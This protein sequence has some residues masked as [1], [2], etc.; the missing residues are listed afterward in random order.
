MVDWLMRRV[1]PALRRFA[2]AA[3]ALIVA[4]LAMSSPLPPLALPT[5]TRLAA[6]QSALPGSGIEATTLA[7]RHLDEA[8]SDRRWVLRRG[9]PLNEDAHAHAG[10]FVYAAIGASYL[11]VEDTQG[12]L[13]QEGQAAWAPGGIG[14][15]H[16]TP[17]RASNRERASSTA[18]TEIWTILLER[19]TD[20]RRPGAAATSP[21]LLQLPPGPYEARLVALTFQP[22][23][24]TAFRSRTGPELAYTL[25]GSWELE[26]A[27]VPF[28][29][30]VS[31]GY[32]AD[33]G[34]PH[35]LRNV[36]ET[37][38]RLLSAQLVPAGQP[39]EEPS[40]AQAPNPRSQR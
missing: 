37:P 32:L 18:E 11:V 15:L 2:S 22:S 27:G 16:A 7:T 31:Q 20:S 39:A 21:P 8:P 28:S 14:H 17:F 1:Q 25:S 38:A 12:S 6:A 10:G 3:G 5:S 34:V 29:L 35:R 9:H 36:G 13:M 23:V 4:A 19:E 40:S 30:G 24:A 33:P 26:Y